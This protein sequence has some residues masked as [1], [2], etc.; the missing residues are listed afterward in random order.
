MLFK[1][2]PFKYCKVQGCDHYGTS[3]VPALAL[4]SGYCLL[5]QRWSSSPENKVSCY[6][7]HSSRFWSKDYCCKS[8]SFWC[9]ASLI[10]ILIIKTC[11]KKFR[12]VNQINL[13]V[14]NQGIQASFSSELQ[15]LFQV[16]SVSIWNN[17]HMINL[18]GLWFSENFLGI[19]F[20][21]PALT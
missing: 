20:F 6:F 13:L 5:Q 16:I 1:C 8:F 3:H 12:I 2:K 15:V 7:S 11:T 18:L 10:P 19:L 14:S 4:V 9:F 17:L 21:P